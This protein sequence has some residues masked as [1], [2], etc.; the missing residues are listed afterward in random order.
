MEFKMHLSA[1]MAGMRRT[2]SDNLMRD[3]EGRK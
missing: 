1:L 3:K 2:A